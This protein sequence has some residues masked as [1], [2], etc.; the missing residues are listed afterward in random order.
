MIER[1]RRFLVASLPDPLPEPARIVQG[2]L[3]THPVS[4]RV[5][6]IDDRLILT[7][8]TGTGLARTEIERDLESDEFDA[9]WAEANELQIEK[10]RHRIGLSGGLTAELDLF[11]GDLAGNRIVEVEFTDDETAAAFEPPVWFGR[12][13]TDDLRYTNAALAREGWP[14][15]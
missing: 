7:I 6:R 15:D 11:D 14:P 3:V 13:V 12:E 2:Y 8:K 4:V 10:R 9:L 5:R 1:E